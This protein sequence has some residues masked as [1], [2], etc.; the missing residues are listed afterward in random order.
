MS[1]FHVVTKSLLSK[2][3]YIH[4]TINNLTTN[5]DLKYSY[6]ILYDCLIHCAYLALPRVLTRNICLDKDLLGEAY[7]YRRRSRISIRAKSVKT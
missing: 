2:F 7:N 1:I 4:I 5:N 3:F 6:G